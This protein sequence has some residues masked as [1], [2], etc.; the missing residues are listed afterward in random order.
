MKHLDYFYEINEDLTEPVSTESIG[1][2]VVE[3]V[4]TRGVAG[5]FELKQGDQIMVEP[6]KMPRSYRV[7]SAGGMTEVSATVIDDLIESG[8][9]TQTK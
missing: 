3:G 4:S 9:I 1:Y 7:I 8:K 6:G 5:K 2:D